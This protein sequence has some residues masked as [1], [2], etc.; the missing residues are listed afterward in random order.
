MQELSPGSFVGPYAIEAEIGRGGMARVYR[1][2]QVSLTRTV[3]LKILAPDLAP[4]GLFVARFHREATIIAALEHPNIVPIYDVGEAFGH[5]YL[6]MR[7]VPGPSLAAALTKDGAFS[8]ERTLVI[9][10][11]IASALDYAHQHGVV[12]RDLKPANILLEGA[13]RAYLADFGIARPAEGTQLTQ[14][15]QIAGTPAYM[16]PEQVLGQAVTAR[17]DL[18]ALGI[19]AF[20]LLTGRVPFNA[21]SDVAVLHQQAYEPPP[22]AHALRPDLPAFVGTALAIMLA[23]SPEDRFGTAAEFVAALGGAALSP[24][25][26]SSGARAPARSGAARRSGW[27]PAAAAAAVF[28]VLV[29]VFIGSTAQR[30]ASVDAVPT[31]SLAGP[32]APRATTL[33]FNPLDAPA[34]AVPTRVPATPVLTATPATVNAATECARRMSEIDAVWDSNPVGAIQRLEDTVRWDATC[35]GATAKLYAARVNRAGSLLNDDQPTDAESLLQQALRDNPAGGEATVLERKTSEYLAGKRAVSSGDWAAAI[36]QLSRLHDEQAGFANGRPDE[37]LAT[38]YV[39]YGNAFAA[40]QD[41][42]HA[43]DQYAGAH[44][45]KPDDGQIQQLFDQAQAHLRPAQAP[46]AAPSISPQ[47]RQ[48]VLEA[49]QRANNAWARARESLNTDDLLDGVTGQELRADTA[50][51]NEL[52]RQGHY[53]VSHPVSSVVTSVTSA[54]PN[55][56]IVTTRESWYD[57]IYSVETRGLIKRE[58]PSSNNETYTVEQQS[59]RWIVTSNALH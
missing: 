1:A 30:A 54:G 37:L 45:L 55:R 28:G 5:P 56:V 57:E 48:A 4:D 36:E 26:R 17:T 31:A 15:G 27:I 38:A 35:G 29:L 11:Q 13:D 16:A 8:L 43:R 3:A 19:L 53:A 40:A 32:E 14:L 21:N 50:E 39:N 44:A 42:T 33:A 2:R 9:L 22:L 23:K 18:Y 52:S 51:V 47:T 59:G 20:E 24:A 49:V 7:Y 25:A 34:T 10:T 58:A 6:A 46:D 12:H 41:W